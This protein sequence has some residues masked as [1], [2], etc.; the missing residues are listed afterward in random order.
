MLP[1]DAS[2]K[3]TKFDV[4]WGSNLDPTRGAYS[5]PLDP[6]AGFKGPTSKGRWKEGGM[7]R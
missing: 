5:T 6:L 4:G 1:K 3:C 7:E 2:P